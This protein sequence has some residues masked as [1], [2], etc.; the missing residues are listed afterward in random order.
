[1]LLAPR[2]R[3]RARSLGAFLPLLEDVLA[4]QFRLELGVYVLGAIGAADRSAVESHLAG[5]A[6]CRN[7]L[8]EL[9]ALPG[10]L[11][12]VTAD[13]AESLVL[14]PDDGCGRRQSLPASPGRRPHRR[15][16]ATTGKHH[17]D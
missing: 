7:E 17:R 2:P 12:R 1:M 16:R 9:A 10:L 11:G 5:C 15:R 14:P 13:E 4:D 6:D 8:A 3:T